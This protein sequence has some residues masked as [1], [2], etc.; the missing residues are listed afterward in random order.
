[1]GAGAQ[2]QQEVKDVGGGLLIATVKDAD[3]NILGFRQSP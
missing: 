2:S 3:G 1:L